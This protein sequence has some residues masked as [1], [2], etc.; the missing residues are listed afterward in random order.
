MAEHPNLAL[1]WS[2][3]PCRYTG[4]DVLLMPASSDGLSV[5]DSF[6]SYD[7]SPYDRSN[8]GFHPSMLDF[9]SSL[10]AEQRMVP[11]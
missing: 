11:S 8:I 10:E 7:P 6:R 5:G 2:I 1:F 4:Q 9:R 3:S